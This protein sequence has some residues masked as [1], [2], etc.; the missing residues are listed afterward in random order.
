MA[1]RK[2]PRPRRRSAPKQWTVMVY[3]AAEDSLQLDATAVQDLREME[4]AGSGESVNVVV[5]INRAWPDFPQRYEVGG[6]L[7]GSLLIESANSQN[8]GDPQSLKD[9]L[10]W[11]AGPKYRAKNYLLVLWGHAYGLGF[12]RDHDD[13]LT[14]KDLDSALNAFKTYRRKKLDLLG[15]NACAMS[16]AEAAFQ[17][18]ESTHY[19]VASQIAVPFAGWPY[20]SI[21]RAINNETKPEQLGKIIVDS[22]VDHFASSASDKQVSMTL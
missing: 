17:L 6:R 22:Y 1:V 13:A 2:R 11:A 5:Q 16:Y 20:E 14:L 12:G 10:L 9:F 21:L 3:M 8:M 19:L 15:V 18:K 4:R 7:E